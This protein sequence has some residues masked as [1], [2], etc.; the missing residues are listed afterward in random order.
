MNSKE[1]GITVSSQRKAV[2]GKS[3]LWNQLS[4]VVFPLCLMTPWPVKMIASLGT[5]KLIKNHVCTIAT[6][7]ELPLSTGT[8]KLTLD[9]SW[10]CAPSSAHSEKSTYQSHQQLLLIILLLKERYQP[11][12]WNKASKNQS[13]TWHYRN[14]AIL[15]PA[16]ELLRNIYKQ[17]LWLD[18]LT[19]RTKIVT[20]QGLCNRELRNRK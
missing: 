16:S 2:L 3:I 10:G 13:K 17:K 20:N 7:S 9:I 15:Q 8:Y 1:D 14:T 18:L 4:I 5:Q 19:Y 6:L 11:F 12:L